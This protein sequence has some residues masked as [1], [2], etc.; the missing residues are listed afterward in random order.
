[1][2]ASTAARFEELYKRALDGEIDD[3]RPLTHFLERE[4]TPNLD[5]DQSHAI[6]NLLNVRFRKYD[7]KDFCDGAGVD[8]AWD[9]SAWITKFIQSN[10]EGVTDHGRGLSELWDS[11]W[12]FIYGSIQPLIAGDLLQPQHEREEE[13][14]MLGAMAGLLLQLNDDPSTWPRMIQTRGFIP[15]VVFLWVAE[16]RGAA[17]Q[18][19]AYSFRITLLLRGLLTDMT[20]DVLQNFVQQFQEY[21][22]LIARAVT[23][24]LHLACVHDYLI[25][26]YMPLIID[27]MSDLSFMN[28]GFYRAF[29]ASGSVT[30]GTKLLFRLA[31][32]LPR[33]PDA[34]RDECY[35]MTLKAILSFLYTVIASDSA[36][37]PVA[38]AEACNAGLLQALLQCDPEVPNSG[39]ADYYH[40]LEKVLPSY[41]VDSGVLHLLNECISSVQRWSGCPEVM[42]RLSPG[43]SI[44]WKNFTDAIRDAQIASAAGGSTPG[45]AP[46]P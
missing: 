35:D 44:A 21:S 11:A 37:G 7:H 38:L 41:A 43:M 9:A 27:M 33:Q 2:D 29:V 45:S 1:M 25:E 46:V 30:A 24:Y 13:D 6:L 36:L 39:Y 12:S 14:F 4:D 40:L 5:T 32:S 17:E 10:P 31:F 20:N 22:P 19:D 23:P 8:L 42:A 18:N 16:I 3:L 28:H 15:T 26:D 34:A